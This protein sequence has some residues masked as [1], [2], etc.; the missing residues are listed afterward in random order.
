M[1]VTEQDRRALYDGLAEA[2]GS[3]SAGV[4]MDLLPRSPSGDFVTRTD[5]QA[6]TIALRGEMAE[7]RAQLTG[8]MAELRGEMAELRAELRGEMADLRTEL[9]GEM[10]VLGTELRGEMAELRT[11]LTAAIVAVRED[12]AELRADI[13]RWIIGAGLSIAA[14]MVTLVL[15]VWRLAG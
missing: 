9:R 8:E 2:I 1:D 4:L 13:G 11:D 12:G 10:A 6:N 3:D 15:L 7:M 14:L 5:M